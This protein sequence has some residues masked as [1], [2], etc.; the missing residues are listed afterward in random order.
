MFDHVTIRASDRE[1]SERF[2]EAMLGTIG[3]ERS[4]SG[5]ALTEWDDFSLAPA[6]AEKPATRHLHI[7]AAEAGHADNGAPGQRPQ[8]HPGYYS[9]YVLDPDGN[10]VEVVSHNR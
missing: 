9:A 1:A 4:H 8:Y 7:Q 5:E 6:D 10:D 2:Y 3:I